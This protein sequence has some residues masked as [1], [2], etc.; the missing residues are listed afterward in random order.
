M[1][2]HQ[3]NRYRCLAVLVSSDFVSCATVRCQWA[4]K[5][6]DNSQSL[7]GLALAALITLTLAWSVQDSTGA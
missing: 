1:T 2:V 4:K 3:A 6:N 5:R 7:T